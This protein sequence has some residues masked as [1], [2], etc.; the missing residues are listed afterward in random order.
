MHIRF[1][2]LIF[3]A[4]VISLVS[5]AYGLNYM[6]CTD[7]EV[8]VL[9]QRMHFS[10]MDSLM[11]PIRSNDCFGSNPLQLPY[12]YDFLMMAC[13][14]FA[15]GPYFRGSYVITDAPTLSFPHVVTSIRQQAAAQ[16]NFYSF[17]GMQYRVQLESRVMRIDYW[18][19]GAAYD[20]TRMIFVPLADSMVV[21]FDAQHV[22]IF[23]TLSTILILG[24]SGQIGLEDNIV[25][26]SSTGPQGQ[27]APNHPEKFAL[28]AEGEIKILNT[29]ANGREN[30]GGLG[31]SQTNPALTSIALN[32]VYCALG[33]SFTFE[34]QN[35]VDSGY[36]Y[37]DPPGSPHTDDRGTIYLW[38]SLTQARRGYV[39]RSTNGTTGYL[40]QYRY[41]PLLKFWHI[42]VFE[43]QENVLTPASINFGTIQAGRTVQDTVTVRNDFVPLTIDSIRVPSQFQAVRPDSYRWEQP[44]VVTFAPDHA[45]TFADTVRV[46]LDYYQQWFKIPV[47]GTATPNPN[48]SPDVIL[49]PASFSLSVYPNPFNP[50]TQIAFTLPSAERVTVKVFDLLG[51]QISVLQNGLLT[52]GQHRVTF[53]GAQLP[54]G[55]Y[56][57]RLEA[58]SHQRTLKLVLL[59]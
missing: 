19:E 22:R 33:E 39:H 4:L 51:Q 34:Q 42:G 48:G 57:L 38:G 56:F 2:H 25:Y 13:D 50:T 26:T 35:D 59:K 5:L 27:L 31:N 24:A 18:P 10:A 1:Q 36:V 54:A 45:G 3:A 20:S 58:A 11:G 53:D 37:Q 41:D 47:R 14:S 43:G 12:N 52:A 7:S 16:G 17:P 30:S 46:Y 55:I 44:I 40:K 29:T 49:Q 32:G 23:G 21:F 9:G 28:V 6:Y 15:W 8:T